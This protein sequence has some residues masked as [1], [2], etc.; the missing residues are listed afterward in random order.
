[1]SDVRYSHTDNDGDS[2][3]VGAGML[4]ALIG[5]ECPAAGM[6]ALVA[7]RYQYLPD[8]IAALQGILDESDHGTRS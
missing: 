5:V 4:G 2:I 7:V 1:M 6:E 8:L 3:Q